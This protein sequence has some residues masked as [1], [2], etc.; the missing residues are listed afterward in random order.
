MD[1]AFYRSFS[2]TARRTDARTSML[3][4]HRGLTLLEIL[5][6]ITIL[7]IMASL[8]A[9]NYR[10]TLGGAKH[11]LAQQ[12]VAK[13]KDALDQYY[14]EMGIYPGQEDGLAALTRPLPDRNEPLM[15]GKL[16][17]PWGHPYGYV[18][19]GKHGKYDLICYGADGVEGG[20]GE[21]ADIVSWDTDDSNGATLAATQ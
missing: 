2:N 1:C 14:M 5:V 19:P 7:V 15:T 20:D 13:L 9:V 16:Q 6:V 8:L 11:K 12:E 10:G 3:A 18:F 21:N 17:D 4:R